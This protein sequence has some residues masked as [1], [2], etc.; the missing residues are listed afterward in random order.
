VQQAG[1]ALRKR[2]LG[3]LKI[4][5]LSSA[6]LE[7]FAA[8][9]VAGVALYVGLTYLGFL[10]LASGLSLRS[11]LFCL[12]MAPEVYQPLRLLAA[13]YHDKKSAE[14]ALDE[15]EAQAGN[16]A[17]PLRPAAPPMTVSSSNMYGA[18]R[19]LSLEIR[20]L[21]ISASNSRAILKDVTL[22]IPAGEHAVLLGESGAGK[23]SL[24]QT[25][26]RLRAADGE[27]QIG[28]RCIAEISE[29]DFRRRVAILNQKPFLFRGSIAD[30]LRL[31][32]PDATNAEL[33]RAGEM[34]CLFRQSPER[35]LRLDT[36]LGD[37]GSGISGGQIQ[38][39]SLARIFLRDPGVLLLD[40]PTAHLDPATEAAVLDA[41]VAFA[42]GRT[43]LI[44]THSNAVIDRFS[45]GFRIAEGTIL[46]ARCPIPPYAEADAA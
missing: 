9:G 16:L 32:N 41:L 18:T 2:T 5:F 46:P 36:F 1:D 23:T 25:I 21:S 27:I 35:A 13:H 24:L 11:G 33:Y 38:R 22:D 19:C 8:L 39:L 29:R 14:S 20:Q 37:D 43:M 30:N 40:E 42:K 15:I 10:H 45:H 6:I 28:G 44:S 31:A 26:A 12:L 34:A 3:V 4:A 7:F 17:M